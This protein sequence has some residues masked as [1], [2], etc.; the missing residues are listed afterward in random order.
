MNISA[1]TIVFVSRLDADCSLG[2]RLLCL[3][4]PDLAARFPDLRIV[5]C[6]GGSELSNITELAEKINQRLI[7]SQKVKRKIN[8]QLGNCEFLCENALANAEKS[9]RRLISCVGAVEDPRAY[10]ADASLFV[11]ASRAALEAMSHGLPTILLG[12]EGYLGILDGEKVAAALAT[13]LTC[14]GYCAPRGVENAR[15]ESELKTKMS[16]IA[17]NLAESES[18]SSEIEQSVS[19]PTSDFIKTAPTGTVGAFGRASAPKSGARGG[20]FCGSPCSADE[21]CAEICRYFEMS[22]Q[23]K[24]ALSRLSRELVERYFSSEE[25]ARQ[26][27]DFYADVLTDMRAPRKKVAICGYYGRGN[28][29]DDAILSMLCAHLWGENLPD[30]GDK[31]SEKCQDSAHSARFVGESGEKSRTADGSEAARELEL[32]LVGG[33]NPLKLARALFGADVFIFGGG[34][35]LQNVTS[36]GSLLWYL[37]VIALARA[38]CGR[39]VMLSNGLG[40]IVGEG[41]WGRFLRSIT[42]CALDLFDEMTVRDRNSRLLLSEL[43]P[44]REVGYLPDPAF[45]YFSENVHKGALN[46][47]NSD[48][49]NKFTIENGA[50]FVFILCSGGLKRVGASA[51]VLKE[52]IDR[53][54]LMMSAHPVIVLLNE[55]EDGKMARKIATAGCEAADVVAPKSPAELC[56]VLGGARFVLSQRYHGVLFAAGVGV[57]TVGLSD[58]PKTVALCA[59]LGLPCLAPRALCPRIAEKYTRAAHK[60]PAP[61][62]FPCAT[63]TKSTRAAAKPTLALRV[64]AAV[65]RFESDAAARSRL[66]AAFDTRALAAARGLARLRREL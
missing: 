33:K 41:A 13:N 39:L 28:F 37:G 26:T 35:L 9:N 15:A 48:Y 14:R 19:E 29:G 60:F 59:E 2:A 10:F 24:Y 8:R 27:L 30:F 23:E 55:T 66:R 58:D 49:K 12:N 34:S 64:R 7:N 45:A 5:I 52:E 20:N 6:G 32:H 62:H 53:I 56:S 16:E 46:V 54:S 42:A 21:L 43:L 36:N 4:A 17:A 38:T 11:G 51:R 44:R 1:H 50:Y 25:M 3:A 61:A 63:A 65:L 31:L 47:S 40:P 57:P 18:N 22:E